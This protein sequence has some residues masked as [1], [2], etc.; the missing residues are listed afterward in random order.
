MPLKNNG[1]GNTSST[2]YLDD[3]EQLKAINLK[4]D[5][6]QRREKTKAIVPPQ[7][8]VDQETENLEAIQKVEISR[9]K[10]LW[11]AH[12]QEQIDEASEEF[13]HMTREEKHTHNQGHHDVR[14]LHPQGQDYATFV[15]NNT[16]PLLVNL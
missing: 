9:Q 10:M 2:L 7:D 6:D 3:Q 8:N 1:V 11:V 5:T 14:D 4:E 12:L 16:F 15:Y 13:Y